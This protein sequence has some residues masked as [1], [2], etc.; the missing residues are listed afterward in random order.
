MDREKEAKALQRSLAQIDLLTRRSSGSGYL[1][2]LLLKIQPLKVKMY[3]EPNHPRPHLHVDYGKQN[4]VASYAI[5]DGTR[6][7]GFL[8]RKYDAAIRE[9]IAEWNEHLLEV[10][11]RTQA[12]DDAEAILADLRASEL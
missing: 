10:W 3:K 4:H 6:L 5:D 12:G 8:D 11:H 2:L 7:A 9:W 1:E